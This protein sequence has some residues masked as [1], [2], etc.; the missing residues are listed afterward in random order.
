MEIYGTD[1]YSRKMEKRKMITGDKLERYLERCEGEKKPI[2][3]EVFLSDRCN[4]RCNYCR[5]GHESGK[6][7]DYRDFVVYAKRLVE[8]GVRGI[9]LTGGGEPTT[10]PDFGRICQWLERNGVPYGINTNGILPVMSDAKFIKVSMDT[11]DRERYQ[12]IRGRDRLEQVLNNIGDMIHWRDSKKNGTRIGVQ[13]VAT[14]KEDVVSFYDKVKS[15]DVDYIYV[16]PLEGVSVKR[17]SE[18]EV[19][20]W[21]GEERMK[22]TRLVLS[23]KFGL[24]QYSAPWC[25]ANWSVI[26]VDVD[27]NVPY[28]CHRPNEIIGSVMDLNIMEKKREYHVDMRECEKP[29]RLS[30][31]N[32][33]IEEFRKDEE[34]FFV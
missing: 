28:C 32:K 16:R 10:C 23:F 27:G 29:C 21:L 34:W 26:T 2:T 9:I 33:Y 5:Y 3:A 12:R 19:K 30:G 4:L 17:V 6:T 14:N 18:T 15:L 8:M 1:D 20:K 13:C 22:D 7:M 25:L 11:G 31:A 24:A